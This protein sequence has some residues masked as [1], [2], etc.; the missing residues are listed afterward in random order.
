MS[1]QTSYA[2]VEKTQGALVDLGLKNIVTRI[3]EGDI[4]FGLALVQGTADRQV[5]IPAATGVFQGVGVKSNVEYGGESKY[6]DESP[7]SMIEKGR[8]YVPVTT[9]VAKNAQ[10]FFI[11][12]G[13]SAGK[14]CVTGTADST[15]A[16][17]AFFDETVLA[18]GLCAIVIK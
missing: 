12:T 18:G 1:V 14:F 2:I 4:A 3:A 9:N 15:I 7:I 5:K 10:A 13:A 8:I 17:G 6:L 16:T 11:H